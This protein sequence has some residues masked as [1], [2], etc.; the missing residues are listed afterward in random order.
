[1]EADKSALYELIAQ[2]EA[3]FLPLF[4]SAKAGVTTFR[5]T[6]FPSDLTPTA[7]FQKGGMSR[8]LIALKM[9]EAFPERFV[10]LN[11]HVK[12]QLTDIDTEIETLKRM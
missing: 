6:I 5:D 8:N 9:E 3:V 11:D 12:K 4:D 7:C 2:D 1:M 10:L